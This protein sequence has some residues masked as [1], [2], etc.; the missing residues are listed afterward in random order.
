MEKSFFPQWEKIKEKCP[1][2]NGQENLCFPCISIRVKWESK[3]I[4][5]STFQ[6]R[7]VYQILSHVLSICSLSFLQI[8]SN[9]EMLPG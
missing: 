9:A 6:S 4:I 5:S 3:Y 7:I 2:V 1:H 8:M